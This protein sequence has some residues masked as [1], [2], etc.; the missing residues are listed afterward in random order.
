LQQDIN[1]VGGTI[2]AAHLIA[3][4]CPDRHEQQ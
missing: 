1:P 4:S 2:S 3:P